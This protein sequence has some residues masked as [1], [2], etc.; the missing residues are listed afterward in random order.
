VCFP[1]WLFWGCVQASIILVLREVSLAVKAE[2][3]G[4]RDSKAAST[5]EGEALIK[6]AEDLDTL[7]INLEKML[8]D[9]PASGK[10]LGEWLRVTAAL[11]KQL[12]AGAAGMKMDSLGKRIKPIRVTI[13]SA[14]G[15]YVDALPPK[16]PPPST[17]GTVHFP[18]TPTPSPKST[19]A[20][21]GAGIKAIISV[22]G[23]GKVRRLFRQPRRRSSESGKSPTQSPAVDRT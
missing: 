9:E 2:E 19:S 8:S 5:P 20:R 14:A 3:T 11:L 18:R 15:L 12:E 17:T 23:L 6:Q 13:R 4:S 10:P 1:H 21:P 22:P 16:S 7:M